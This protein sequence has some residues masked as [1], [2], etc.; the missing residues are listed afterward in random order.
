MSEYISIIQQVSEI[1]HRLDVLL[2]QLENNKSAYRY[3]IK[4]I[5]ENISS[6]EQE[7]HEALR[8]HQMDK[9]ISKKPSLREV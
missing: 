4:A 7:Y 1:K 2:A 3:R 9:Q 8:Y 6:L 5:S